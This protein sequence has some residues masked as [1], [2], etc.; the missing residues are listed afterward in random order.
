MREAE[1]KQTEEATLLLFITSVCTHCSSTVPWF[2]C[3]YHNI[4]QLATSW[5]WQNK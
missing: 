1:G 4:W 5:N 3:Q 2:S